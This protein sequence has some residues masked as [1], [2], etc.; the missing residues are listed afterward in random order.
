MEKIK[1]V[2]V[3]GINTNSEDNENWSPRACDWIELYT[4][5]S[6]RE[7]DNELGPITRRFKLQK[8]AIELARLIE[9]LAS[10][11]F[12]IKLIGHSN[13]CEIIRRALL[14][15]NVRVEVVHLVAGACDHDFERGEWNRLIREKRIKIIIVH[16]S[17]SDE[18][19][20]FGK[21]TTG[22]LRP[23]GWGYG[24][25]GLIGPKN[26]A[27]ELKDSVVTIW[28]DEIWKGKHLH[29]DYWISERFETT[30]RLIV[31]S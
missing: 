6:A 29:S 21:W 11:G 3:P 16:A 13:G 31:D 14:L 28:H 8:K 20:K 7:F 25:S 10:E 22:W 9:R 18:A 19:L 23:F 24:W 26:V 17:K 15:T 27:L 30:M 2:A 5:D 1:W 12:R 4:N